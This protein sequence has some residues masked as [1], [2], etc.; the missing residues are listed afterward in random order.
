MKCEFCGCTDEMACPE[1]CYWFAEKVCSSCAPEFIAT[2][3]IAGDN[4]VA[5][6]MIRLAQRQKLLPSM[7]R[8]K[9][10]AKGWVPK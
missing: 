4:R 5:T 6:Q 9:R 2:L 8:M 10:L 3:L 1:G 7:A